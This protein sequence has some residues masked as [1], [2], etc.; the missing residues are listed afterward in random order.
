MATTDLCDAFE[1]QV[2]DGRV[3]ILPPMF[4]IYGS[5]TTFSGSIATVKVFEDNVEVRKMVEEAGDG[6]VLVVDGGASLRCALFGGRL[7]QLA[8]INGWSGVVLNACVRDVHE[9]NCCDI[10]VRALGAHPLRSSKKGHGEINVP[11]IIS[12]TRIVPGEWCYADFDGVVISA[13]RLSI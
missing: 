3:R 7:A 4:Q 13:T 2:R 9:I 10:G 8:H 12:G 11:L 5:R 6:R 1:D